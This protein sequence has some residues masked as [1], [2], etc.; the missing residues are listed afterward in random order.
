MAQRDRFD[1]PPPWT[2]AGIALATLVAVLAAYLLAS[3][4]DCSAA[5]GTALCTTALGLVL[6]PAPTWWLRA[7]LRWHRR[8]VLRCK[9]AQLRQAG[10]RIEREASVIE[11]E[12]RL[13][14]RGI[15][16]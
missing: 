3:W 2:G 7:W 11:I 8:A 6:P 1:P 9:A 5:P 14:A 10:Q 4:L 16:P 13:R 15:K 12:R